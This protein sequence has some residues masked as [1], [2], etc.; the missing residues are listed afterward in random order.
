P[1]IQTANISDNSPLIKDKYVFVL[2]DETL[3][4]RRV[5]A[6]Y[7]EGCNNHCYTDEP[8]TDLNNISYISLYV[9]LP[10]HLDLFSDI[11]KESC[12]LLTHHLASNIIYHIDKLGVLIDRNTLKLLEDEK[13]YFDYFSQ[14]D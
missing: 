11:L 1:N 3:Y 4:V 6:L 14:N 2:Y 7:F 9:Y 5:M 10:I 12:N 8:V 13:K